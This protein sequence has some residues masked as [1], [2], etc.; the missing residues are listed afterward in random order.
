MET[1]FDLVTVFCFLA[2]CA[3]YSYNGGRDPRLLRNLLLSGL[4]FAVGN[5]LGNAGLEGFALILIA[6]GIGWAALSV[7]S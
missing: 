1:L 5:Q 3:A 6:P 7:R 2:L 4:C